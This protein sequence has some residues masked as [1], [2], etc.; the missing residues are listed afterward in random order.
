MIITHLQTYKY[1]HIQA[2]TTLNLSKYSDA[3]NVK[4]QHVLYGLVST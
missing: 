4:S 3:S 1:S 2:L